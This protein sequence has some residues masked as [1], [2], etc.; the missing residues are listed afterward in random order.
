MHRQERAQEAVR[1]GR[2]PLQQICGYIHWIYNHSDAGADIV[3][4][5]LA[6]EALRCEEE[7]TAGKTRKEAG[8]HILKNKL[9]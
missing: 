9:Q 7:W 2:R 6:S 1:E 4:A 8:Y 3:S 5:G